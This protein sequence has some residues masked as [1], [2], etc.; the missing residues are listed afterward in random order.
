MKMTNRFI[1]FSFLIL[2]FSCKQ[3]TS[4]IRCTGYTQGTT[5]HISYLSETAKNYQIEFDSILLKIDSSLSTYVSYSTIS[6]INKN[7]I[8]YTKDNLFKKMFQLSDSIFKQTNGYFDPTIEPLIK[9][10]NFD[11]NDSILV[12][13]NLVKETLKRI[14]FDK[15]KMLDSL[16]IK[17]N[18]KVQLNFNAIAQGYSVDIIASFLEKQKINNYLIEIGGEVLAKGRKLNNKKWLI[19]ISKPAN[20]NDNSI[21]KALELE[22]LAL[23]TSGSYRNYKID[24]NSGIK[25]SHTIDP[26]TGFPSNHNLISVSVIAKKCAK[27][28]AYATALMVMDKYLAKDFLEKNS[29]IDAMLIYVNKNNE[30]E[31]FQTK[32]FEEIIIN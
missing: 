29:N 6:K 14:G 9:L 18:P 11:E 7:K 31:I 19:G 5:Y 20:E 1:L 24:K 2:F 17:E 4:L 25:Y 16:I 22:N 23:A 30:W 3:N 27:A 12:D 13:S 32:G 15:I 8:A 28:D 26:H 10:Y 21:Y